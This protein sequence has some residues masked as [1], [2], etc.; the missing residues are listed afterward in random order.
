MEL[1]LLTQIR[2]ILEVANQ[3]ACLEIFSKSSKL[4]VLFRI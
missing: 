4:R 1:H 3:P 2:D